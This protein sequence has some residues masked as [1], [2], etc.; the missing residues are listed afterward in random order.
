[1]ISWPVIIVVGDICHLV[2]SV[3]D[4]ESMGTLRTSPVVNL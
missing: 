1:M 3:L 2:A 4:G